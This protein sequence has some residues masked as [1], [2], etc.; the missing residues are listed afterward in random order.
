MMDNGKTMFCK[1]NVL[2]LAISLKI[3]PLLCLFLFQKWAG[4]YQEEDSGWESS[5]YLHW[6]VFE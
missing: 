4:I 1:E 6:T 2:N 3:I 5:S